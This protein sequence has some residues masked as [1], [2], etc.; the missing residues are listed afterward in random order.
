MVEPMERITINQA[1]NKL[2][3]ADQG[4]PLSAKRV[5]QLI[6]LGQLPRRQD[7]FSNRLFLTNQDIIDF[8]AKERIAHRP[9][10]SLSTVTCEQ[11]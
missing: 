10:K 4:L 3:S 7:E 1:A 5:Y 8:N 9:V 2:L 11:S 6:D